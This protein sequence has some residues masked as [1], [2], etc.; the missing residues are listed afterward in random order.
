MIYGFFLVSVIT[1]GILGF[2]SV[3]ILEK[4]EKDV[5]TISTEYEVIEDNG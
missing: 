3:A 2:F 1:L 4:S 5:G